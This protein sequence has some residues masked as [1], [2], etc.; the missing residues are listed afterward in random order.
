MRLLGRRAEGQTL[1]RLL[2]DTLAGRSRVTVL[3][4]EPGVGKS[5]LLGY[6]SDRAAD[7]HVARAVSVASE[8]ELPTAT[9]INS[10]HRP[11]CGHLRTPGGHADR[12]RCG[13]RRLVSYRHAARTAPD[14]VTGTSEL[15]YR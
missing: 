7:W 6:P 14:P 5:A 4:G 10:A 11:A 13:S 9:S 8:I 3:R 15:L 1:D 12:G 2:A